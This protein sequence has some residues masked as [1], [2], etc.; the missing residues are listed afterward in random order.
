M[1]DYALESTMC[2]LIKY[3]KIREIFYRETKFKI[4]NKMGNQICN[5]VFF[6]ETNCILEIF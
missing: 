4:E 5:F 1:F 6:N 3:D 2:H